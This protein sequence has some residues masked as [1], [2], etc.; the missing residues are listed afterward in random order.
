MSPDTNRWCKRCDA[1]TDHDMR[2]HEQPSA[3]PD[4]LAL[5]KWVLELLSTTDYRRLQIAKEIDAFI[6]ERE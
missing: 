6:T 1:W 5:A 3:C 4:C 2:Q